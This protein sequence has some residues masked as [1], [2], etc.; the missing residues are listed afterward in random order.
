MNVF[1][2]KQPFVH[3]Q[4]PAAMCYEPLVMTGGTYFTIPSHFPS[5]ELFFL[6][7]LKVLVWESATKGQDFS[8]H[9]GLILFQINNGQLLVTWYIFKVSYINTWQFCSS[10]ICPIILPCFPQFD[11]PIMTGTAQR[12]SYIDIILRI[13]SHPLPC[14]Y[15]LFVIPNNHLCLKLL[16][17]IMRFH[18]WRSASWGGVLLIKF[19]M[20]LNSITTT[21][22]TD[23]RGVQVSRN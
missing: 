8:R 11:S 15:R 21:R 7:L 12:G 13:T 6:F 20:V 9:D 18:G 16:L 5:L 1:R 19:W 23:K 14:S 3:L 4:L 2:N 10:A 22:V 17:L